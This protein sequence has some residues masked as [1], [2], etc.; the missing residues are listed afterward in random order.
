MLEKI[1]RCVPVEIELDDHTVKGYT[2]VVN[3]DHALYVGEMSMEKT[4]ERILHASGK[5]GSNRD[6]L[7]ATVKHLDGQGLND[8]ML[9]TLLSLVNQNM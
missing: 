9:K 1:Y 4:A 5:K 6:Y 7:A 3:R 8:K 2:L